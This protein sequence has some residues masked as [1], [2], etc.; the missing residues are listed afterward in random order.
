MPDNSVIDL[1]SGLS[2]VGGSMSLY[3]RLLGKYVEGGYFAKL[4]ENLGAGSLEAATGDAHTIKGVAANLSL[5]GVQAAA[6]ALE[7][8]LKNGEPH[9]ALLGSLRD[10]DDKAKAEIALL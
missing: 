1:D 10:A 4:A 5:V 7:Q 6:L 2:R 8:A 3:K 9:D